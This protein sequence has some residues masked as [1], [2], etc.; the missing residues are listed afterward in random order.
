MV[1]NEQVVIRIVTKEVQKWV[2]GES[3]VDRITTA[4]KDEED[5]EDEDSDSKTDEG[6]E[7]VTVEESKVFT[8]RV[9]DMRWI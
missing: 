1:E 8:L 2:R 7:L 9:R 6:E 4:A 3:S 5:E